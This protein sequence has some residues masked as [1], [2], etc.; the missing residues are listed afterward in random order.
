M[1]EHEEILLW[2]LL[3]CVHQFHEEVKELRLL[4]RKCEMH[5]L[6]HRYNIILEIDSY[7]V[8]LCKTHR[9]INEIHVSYNSCTLYEYCIH[10]KYRCKSLVNFFE[11]QED[12]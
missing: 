4:V 5:Y 9:S 12:V 11:H 10:T 3:V 6:N 1:F 8:V 7:F 2:V